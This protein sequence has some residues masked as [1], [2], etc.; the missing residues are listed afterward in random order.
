[1]AKRIKDIDVEVGK[2]IQEFRRIRGISQ[3]VIADAIGVTFQQV[4]KYEKGTNR[5]S[6]GALVNICK[7]LK[8]DPMDILGV[9]FGNED[10]I[11]VPMIMAENATLHRKISAIQSAVQQI[12]A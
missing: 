10:G 11:G 3:T 1:M 4:Q 7:V 8:I 2:R 6:V 9:Y 5:I 12:C